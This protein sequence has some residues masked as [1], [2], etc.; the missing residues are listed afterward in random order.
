MH[1]ISDILKY[2]A[3][4]QLIIMQIFD[5]FLNILFQYFTSLNQHLN[6]VELS[7][8]FCN[9]APGRV[10]HGKQ[11]KGIRMGHLPTMTINKTRTFM[12]PRLM[13]PHSGARPGVGL[14]DVIVVAGS[15]STGP[16]QARPEMMTWVCLSV[17]ASAIWFGWHHGLNDPI[18]RTNSPG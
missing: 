15:L 16:G 5:N 11:G 7:C 3:M 13:W 9:D 14:A 10:S 1:I 8:R 18:L 12:L 4:N 17:G 2:I 6:V